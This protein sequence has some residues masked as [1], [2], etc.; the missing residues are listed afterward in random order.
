MRRRLRSVA[1][2]GLLMAACDTA[3]LRPMQ[4]ALTVRYDSLRT[5]L[6]PAARDSLQAGQ[7]LWVAF[8]PRA[9]DQ[10]GGDSLTFACARRRFAERLALLE[11]SDEIALGVRTYPQSIYRIVKSAAGVEAH[12]QAIIEWQRVGLDA[13]ETND[14][15]RALAEALTRWLEAE[16]GTLTIDSVADL[17]VDR[18]LRR[19]SAPGFLVLETRRDRLEHRTDTRVA[20]TTRVYFSIDLARP[21]APD[22]VPAIDPR[23]AADRR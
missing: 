9:C 8:W 18:S 23:G 19:T 21:L 13:M 10:D 20:D 1:A 14:G 12:P 5:S 11:S 7:D 6:S 2:L 16:Q 3:G 15:A 22:E 17:R 4:A